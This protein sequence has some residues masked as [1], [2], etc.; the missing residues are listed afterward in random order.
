M[1][2]KVSSLIVVGIMAIT[3][4]G[5]ETAGKEVAFTL[6]RF[7]A[8]EVSNKPNYKVVNGFAG[9]VRG[10]D[11][12]TDGDTQSVLRPRYEPEPTPSRYEPEAQ[13][14][15]VYEREEPA[16]KP[17]KIFG[18]FKKWRTPATAQSISYDESGS[19]QRARPA[20]METSS[21]GGNCHN[22]FTSSPSDYVS[23]GYDMIEPCRG[24]D[25]ITAY[26][27]DGT[28]MKQRFFVPHSG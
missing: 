25:W 4:V 1:G 27:Q 2:K 5:C 17:A 18:L 16:G 15:S 3:T 26:R 19:A 22:A 9:I 28:M 20:V 21:S 6:M 23:N 8:G 24:G 13:I 7:E 10:N 11:V 14:P 12:V